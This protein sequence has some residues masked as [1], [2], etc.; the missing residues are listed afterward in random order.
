M[1]PP[2]EVVGTAVA[3]EESW[4]GT[5][6]GRRQRRGGARRRRQQRRAGRRHRHPLRVGRRSCAQ[7]QVLVELDTSVE[8]AQLASARGAQGSGAPIDARPLA[9]ARRARGDRRRRSSTPTRRSSRRRA[10]T[11]ARSQA[12]IDRKTVRAP[13]A[14]RLGI[15]AVNLGQ[16]LQPGHARSPCSRRSTRSTSTSRCRSSASA[17]SRSGMPV[18]VTIEGAAAAPR[19]RRRSRAIDPTIDATTRTIKLRAE[20]PEQGREAAPGHVRQRRGRAAATQGRVV[21][22]P[23]TAVVHASYGDSVFVVED[24]KDDRARGARRQAGE[25]RAPAVRA[26]RARRAATSSRS[27]TAS[28]PGRR[29]SPPA[30][31]SCATARGVIVNNDVKPTPQLAPHPENR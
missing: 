27:S 30:R 31:S 3:T 10:P 22:V 15:R 16:Y 17:T 7:G 26:R 2:P 12:Q 21:T 29:W 8:R 11:S 25:G 5:L 19:R 13:F 24:K 6:V 14:G 23:A 9:R 28:R 4:E 18:R 20:R 1:G